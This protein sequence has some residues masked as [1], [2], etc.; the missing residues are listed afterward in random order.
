MFSQDRGTTF[1]DIFD[2]QR[3]IDRLLNDD[4]LSGGGGSC[5]E[6]SVSAT[7]SA[8]ADHFNVF[9]CQ[10]RV[11][12]RFKIDFILTGHLLRSGSAVTVK[13]L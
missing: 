1:N 12:V 10:E 7:R 4:M 3:D 2:F 6:F 11:E 13:S 5:A 8:D 9:P